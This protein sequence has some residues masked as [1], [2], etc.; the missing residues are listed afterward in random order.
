MLPF[1]GKKGVIMGVANNRSIATAVAETLHAQGASLGFSFLPDGTGK[2]EKRVASAIEQVGPAFLEPCDVGTD[3][4]I[5]GFF[6]KVEQHFGQIDFLV[7]SIAFAPIEEI[8]KPTLEVSRQGFLQAMEISAY[9]LIAAAQAAAK[10]MTPGGSICAMT[11]F[12]GEKVIP[13]YN[14]MGVCKAALEHSIRYIA[15]DLGSKNLRCNGI[16]A[17]PI[18]TLASSAVGDFKDMLKVNAAMS[19][20]GRNVS[21]EDVGKAAAFLLSEHASA[22]TGEILHVD[23]GYHIMGGPTSA[24]MAAIKP[25]S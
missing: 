15:Y 2:M 5:Q 3:Q 23:S 25:G 13:G 18:R 22:I 24:L 6:G 14:L 11:Y 16:S 1:Q 7:H 4:G 8:R 12:G 20:L 17:G 9:S 10:M 19:P 21:Q